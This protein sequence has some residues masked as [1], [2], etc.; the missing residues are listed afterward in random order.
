MLVAAPTVAE[1][2]RKEGTP[3]HR[4]GDVGRGARD[5]Q[6]VR[7]RWRHC[8]V[9]ARLAPGVAERLRGSDEAHEGFA[10]EA[11]RRDALKPGD[12]AIWKG[13]GRNR[14][15]WCWDRV[16]TEPPPPLCSVRIYRPPQT[17][18]DARAAPRPCPDET[19][20]RR[21]E[22]TAWRVRPIRLLIAANGARTE[23]IIMMR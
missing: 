15:V 13:F 14:A 3:A 2:L 17:E 22:V 8:S 20:D 5:V 6:G 19:F 7:A 11:T 4:Q 12:K 10:V 18:Q 23:F 1:I 9:R 21:P 16:G